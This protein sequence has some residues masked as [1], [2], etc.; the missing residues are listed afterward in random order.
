MN[1]PNCNTPLGENDVF[2]L[3]CG[4]K[5]V[6]EEAPQEVPVQAPQEAA[7]VENQYAAPNNVYTDPASY[8]APNNVYTDP[9][10]YAAPNAYNAPN[11]QHAAPNAYNAPNQQY[12]AP[13]AYNPNPQ[14]AAPNAYNNPN[15]QYAPPAAPKK[16]T[17]PL[18]VV[19]NLFTTVTTN[20]MNF[21]NNNEKVRKILFKEDGKINVVVPAAAGGVVVVLIAIGIIASASGSPK[22]VAKDYLK[23]ECED[24]LYTVVENEVIDHDVIKDLLKTLADDEG[25]SEKEMYERFASNI[26]ESDA[27]FNNYKGFAKYISEKAEEEEKEWLADVYGDDYKIKV[28]VESPE[29]CTKS[30]SEDY[31]D[32]L[33]DVISYI[34]RNTDTNL[35]FDADDAKK[36]VEVDYTITIE[37]SED[38]DRD[39]GTLVFVKIKGDWKVLDSSLESFAGYVDFD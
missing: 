23:A 29:K 1:C 7:P 14:Y 30:R 5:I 15:V 37:G 17:D 39:R 13:N 21:V 10:S 33:E 16:K 35:D 36:F 26:D 3:N 2:C 25:F 6:K 24:N 12:A 19:K 20:I 22:A 18:E 31:R 32:N 11:P 8:A 27:D 9:A 28:E 34:E 38:R 4:Q